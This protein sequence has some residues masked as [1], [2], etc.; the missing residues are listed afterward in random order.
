MKT[1]HVD[2]VAEVY[3]IK[4]RCRKVD[5][6]RI[7][8]VTIDDNGAS[9]LVFDDDMKAK[10]S[11]AVHQGMKEVRSQI[12]VHYHPSTRERKES[13]LSIKSI[14]IPCDRYRRFFL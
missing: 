13:G 11:T 2:I 12:V 1:H 8:I 7:N 3:G 4:K 9:E 6:H 5:R 14:T 10:V